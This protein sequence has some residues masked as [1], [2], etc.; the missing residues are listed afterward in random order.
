MSD[1]ETEQPETQLDPLPAPEPPK[2]SWYRKRSNQVAIGLLFF[3]VVVPVLKAVV[4]EDGASDTEIAKALGAS[5]TPRDADLRLVDETSTYTAA[6]NAA[7]TPLVRDWL[8]DEVSALEWVEEAPAHLA[9]LETALAGF[10]RTVE[11]IDDVGLRS[12]FTPLVNNYGDK[13]AAWNALV[14]AVAEGTDADIEAAIDRTDA[15]GQAGQ[16]LARELMA[17]MEPL[18]TES[19]RGLLRDRIDEQTENLKRDLGL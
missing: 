1:A 3:F 13:L 11:A 18:L 4:A 8:D 19:D 15:V 16:R 17:R 6:W 7:A 12:A 5:G 14:V 2:T 10:R 9:R